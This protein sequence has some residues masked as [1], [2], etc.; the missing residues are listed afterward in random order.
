M[1]IKEGRNSGGLTRVLLGSLATLI[2]ALFI[3]GGLFHLLG[4]VMGVA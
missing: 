4:I 3:W 1:L 2:A